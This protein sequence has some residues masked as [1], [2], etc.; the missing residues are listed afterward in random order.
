MTDKKGPT[1]AGGTA[2]AGQPDSVRNVALVGHSGS[3]K[4]TLVEALLA[5]TGGIQRAGR[6]EDGSP[7]SAT[8]TRWRSASSAR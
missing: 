8:S 1:P 7:R 2:A 5:Y 3:G 6:V 4:T